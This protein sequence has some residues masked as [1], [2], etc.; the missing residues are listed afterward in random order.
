MEPPSC[1]RGS[2][3]PSG[4]IFLDIGRRSS[5]PQRPPAD[6]APAES[7]RPSDAVDGGISAALRLGDIAAEGGDAEHAA[8]I[9]E[10]SAAG[11]TRHAEEEGDRVVMGGIAE[12]ADLGAFQRLAGI[13]L[14]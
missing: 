1:H 2:L 8:A 6:V 10:N 14:R 5:A 9:G 4:S 13:A 12:P 11:G 3:A 7:L